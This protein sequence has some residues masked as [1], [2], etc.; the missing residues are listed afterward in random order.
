M[1]FTQTPGFNSQNLFDRIKNDALQRTSSTNEKPSNLYIQEEIL[2]SGTIIQSQRQEIFLEQNTVL[3]FADDAPGFNWSHPCHYLLYELER[4]SIKQV[5]AQLPPYLTEIPESYQ[6]FHEQFPIPTE[7][8]TWNVPR[9]PGPSQEARKGN[10]YAVLF[11]GAS[12]N[13]HLND[14]EFLYRTLMDVYGYLEDNI[15]VLNFDGTL[16]YAGNPKPVSNWPG[17]NTPY[18]IKVNAAGTKSELENVLDDLKL[19]LREQD[20]VFIHTSNHGYHDSTESLLIAYSPPDY[21]ASDFA[22]KLATFPQFDSLNVMMEQCNSGGFNAPLVSASPARKTSVA[23]ACEELRPSKGGPHFDPFARDW[24]AAMNGSDPY[25]APLSFN[26]DTDGNGGVTVQ[27][28]FSYASAIKDP[29]DTPVYD[30]SSP[31]AGDCRLG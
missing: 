14:L 25:G 5:P 19:R 20:S 2:P 21:S 30:Q 7:E 31:T 4:P 18:R 1:V 22:A 27:E 24:I 28:A 10:G 11:S 16:N 9:S 29:V 26:P 12:N 23:S 8:T 15:Y 13:R 6:M 17:D 3:V